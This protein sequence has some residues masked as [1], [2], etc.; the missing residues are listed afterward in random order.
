MIRSRRKLPSLALGCLVLLTVSSGCA[1]PEPRRLDE[2]VVRDGRYL[3]PADFEPYT[4]PVFSVFDGNSASVELRTRLAAGR[5][6][7]PYERFYR[8]GSLFGTGSYSDGEWH[9]PFETFYE[10]GSP[11]MKGSYDQGVL[12]GPFEELD[13]GG[14]VIERG[15][16]RAGEPCGTWQ[17]GL[18]QVAH[19]PC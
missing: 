18:E 7:G 19:P 15:A 14:Q 4:G 2:L 10:D 3:D 1:D 5:F 13:Q 11:W 17:V 9:G 6:D 12:T 8:S 16:Y